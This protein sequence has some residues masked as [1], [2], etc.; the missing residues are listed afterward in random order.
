[1]CLGCLIVAARCVIVRTSDFACR[2]VA[3][4][5]DLRKYSGLQTFGFSGTREALEC[6]SDIN[7]HAVRK[8]MRRRAG[9]KNLKTGPWR[10][11]RVTVHVV[12]GRKA[13]DNRRPHRNTNAGDAVGL[14][15][16]FPRE[17]WARGGKLAETPMI[18]KCGARR[19]KARSG[20]RSDRR[21]GGGGVA[22]GGVWLCLG[23]PKPKRAATPEAA[24]LSAAPPPGWVL[25]SKLPPPRWEHLGGRSDSSRPVAR[26]RRRQMS[27]SGCRRRHGA[28]P[29]SPTTAPPARLPATGHI[30]LGLAGQP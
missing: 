6:H 20:S 19:C 25:P 29:A 11:H 13:T 7:L 15:V 10:P 9:E 16:D 21:V 23:T 18:G 1:M 30:D 8:S 5:P 14:P 12:R 3:D 4:F 17:R 2:Q 22:R 26:S 27:V 28:A 24:D